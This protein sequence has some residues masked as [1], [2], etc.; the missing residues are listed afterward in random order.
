MRRIATV[1]D[2]DAP[3]EAIWRVLVNFPAYPDWNPFL[4]ISGEAKVGARLEVTAQPEGHKPMTF[5]PTVLRSRPI[6][7]YAG[8]VAW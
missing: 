7:S 4:R 1:I 3:A 5:R 2:I 8:L 6:A